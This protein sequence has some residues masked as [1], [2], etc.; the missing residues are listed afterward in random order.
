MWQALRLYCCR[1]DCK[2]SQ[3][4]DNSNYQ[5]HVFDTSR[6]LT[7]MRLIGYW[8]GAQFVGCHWKSKLIEAER[9]IY[10]PSHIWTN[11][12][13][14]LIGL[15]GT[16]LRE[17]SIAIHMFSFKK[18]HLKISSAK[19]RPFCLGLSVLFKFKFKFKI[20]YCFLFTVLVIHTFNLFSSTTTSIHNS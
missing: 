19:W 4:C 20:V 18:M 2:I 10:A 1:D 12:R 15:L 16:N 13:I 11:A 5:S 7:T 9:R 17:I 3:L 6:D 14:L 8:N